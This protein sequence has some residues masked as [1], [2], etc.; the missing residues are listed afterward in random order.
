M[1]TEEVDR[2]FHQIVPNFDKF[3]RKRVKIE[4]FKIPASR[5]PAEFLDT[6][7]C[8]ISLSYDEN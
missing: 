8:Q 1:K 4:K 7:P 2:C 6:H 3:G 5:G